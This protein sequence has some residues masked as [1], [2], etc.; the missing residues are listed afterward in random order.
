MA[1]Y[2]VIRRK[3]L[4]DGI[5]QREVARELGHSRKTVKKAV[6]H[7]LPLGY[8][9]R[10]PRTQPVLEPVRAMIEAWLEADRERPRKQRHTAQ[11]VFERLR[12]EHQF[13][14]SYSPIQRFVASWK[15][16][17]GLHTS[18]VYV[19]LV[20]AAGEEAQVDWG[21][22]RVLVNG[23]ERTLQ[24]FCVRLAFSRATFVRAYERQDQV[25]FLDGHVRALS[26][27]GGVP[28]RLAYDNLKTAVIRVGRGRE[29]D[30]NQ[31]FVELRSWY[32][33]DTRFCN[34]SSGHEK[35]HVENLVKRV[36][37]TFLTPLPEVSSLEELN[38]QLERDCQRELDQ[39]TR[40]PRDGV[41]RT[42]RELFAEEQA[43]LRPLPTQAYAACDEEATRIDKFSTA[44]FANCSYSVPVEHAHQPCVVRGY[45]DRV[46][47]FCEHECVATHRRGT[48]AAKTAAAKTV[49]DQYVLEPRHYLPLL[50]RKPGLLHN[51]RPFQGEP[52]G[53]D[54]AL[55]RRELEYRYA[56]DGTKQFLRVLLLLTDHPEADVFAA[57][58]KCVALRAFNADAIEN[59]LRNAPL[60]LPSSRLDLSDRPELANVG[61][62]I[63]LATDYDALFE[64][65]RDRDADRDADR[66]TDRDTD[67]DR[68]A[69]SPASRRTSAPGHES[70]IDESLIDESLVDHRGADAA[71]LAETCASFIDTRCCSPDTLCCSGIKVDLVPV[72]D[73]VPITRKEDA[74]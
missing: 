74:A 58:S 13:A 29:R 57:V 66:D 10:Q 45:L 19:P 36:Q 31:K 34:V 46:E 7:P 50:A 35:G 22:A 73:P 27:F 20:F 15:R 44:R 6:E 17:Q 1:Q 61:S 41:E 30:L 40:D 62:G 52:F 49:T 39:T 4:V 54:F 14:G 21:E 63:R 53:P 68:A 23:Q 33:F 26:F 67:A 60:N 12:D 32:L 24:F 56:A 5:S 11:R 64:T 8:R 71:P 65:Q 70:L 16:Q 69:D 42:S 2:E 38:R 25:S 72:P 3:V 48:A 43:Q 55:L 47:I 28:K 18:D 59:T 9:R 37:R 51:G